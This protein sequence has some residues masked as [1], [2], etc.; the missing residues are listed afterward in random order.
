MPLHPKQIEMLTELVSGTQEREL[1]CEE[2]LPHL[3]TWAERILSGKSIDDADPAILHHLK[4]CPE[5]AEE[6]RVLTDVMKENT[7]GTRGN[8]S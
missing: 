3:A 4:I 1:D 8:Y 6:F 7:P 2:V 5:C